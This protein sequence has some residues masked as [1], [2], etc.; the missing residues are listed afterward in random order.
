MKYFL[1]FLYQ[2]VPRS[3]YEMPEYYRVALASSEK[4]LAGYFAVCFFLIYW[5][6]GRWMLQPV[7]MLALVIFALVYGRRLSTRANIV[8]YAVITVLWCG[9]FVHSFGWGCG[10]QHFLLL[11]LMLIFFNVYEP[12]WVKILSWAMLIAYRMALFSYSLHHASAFPLEASASIVFQTVNSVLLFIILALDCIIFSTSIQ[13]TE[14]QL[15][16]DNQEL[17]KEA[18]TD[19]LTGLMNRRAMIDEIESFCRTSPGE[20]YS[21]AIADIDFFK[22]VNDTYGHDCGDYTLR[23]LA[24]LFRAL[25]RSDYIV[26]RWGGEEFCFFLPGKN[27]DEAW[28]VMFGVCSSV[29]KLPLRFDGKEF[30]ITI[31]IGIEENDFRSPMDDIL[32]EADKKLYL[33][34][35]SGRDQV[36]I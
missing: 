7:L 32:K 29:R 3:G 1:D 17:H 9:W 33:G 16:I 34:K 23:T 31:T 30:S 24:D 22:N 10:G 21:V 8:I 15:R 11:L 2:K 5:A 18:G 35:N 6:T 12:A 28:H 4:L 26:C 20:T 27:I 19:P 36:V 13:D 14:R 25:S